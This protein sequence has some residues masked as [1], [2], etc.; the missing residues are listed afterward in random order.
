MKNLEVVFT[1]PVQDA[2]M[3]ELEGSFTSMEALEFKNQMS[4]T[5]KLLQ[6]DCYIDLSKIK[7]F[8]LA[9]LN[10]LV[11]M[12]NDLARSGHKLVINYGKQARVHEIFALTQMDHILQIRA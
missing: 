1:V 10:T 11:R 7:G 8:D 2:L 12:H 3:I 4:R 9:A 5:I 6:K